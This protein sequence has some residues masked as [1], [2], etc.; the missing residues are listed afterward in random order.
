[1]THLGYAL[2]TT[3]VCSGAVLGSGIGKSGATIRWNTATRMVTAWLLT[4]PAA[5]AVGSITGRLAVSGT[6]GIGVD[7]VIGVTASAGFYLLSRRQRVTAE[8][9]APDEAITGP[10]AGL[11]AT[12]TA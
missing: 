3:H 10:A 6:F 8:S 5:A 11:A 1:S 12:P 7:A 4:L 2:S 9:L